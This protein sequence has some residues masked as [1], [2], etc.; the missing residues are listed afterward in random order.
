MRCEER[1]GN[2][3][4]SSTTKRISRKPSKQRTSIWTKIREEER[5][6]SARARYVGWDFFSL[7]DVK[8]CLR[9]YQNKEGKDLEAKSFFGAE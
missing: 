3:R 4:K 2:R 1:T 6:L 8:T 5:G 7:L 9:C